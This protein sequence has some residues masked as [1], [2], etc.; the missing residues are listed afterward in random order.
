M[1]YV[2]TGSRGMV[3]TS[4]HLFDVRMFSFVKVLRCCSDGGGYYY[5][6]FSIQSIF[7]LVPFSYRYDISNCWQTF[8]LTHLLQNKCVWIAFKCR[9][10]VSIHFTGRPLMY[11]EY[12]R[13]LLL[14]CANTT[15]DSSQLQPNPIG[16]ENVESLVSVPVRKQFSPHISQ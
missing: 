10:A 4:R 12:S 2:K 1:L 13:S 16:A 6:Y 5:Y 9:Q 15:L 3:M 8:Q 11:Y 7:I 14:L